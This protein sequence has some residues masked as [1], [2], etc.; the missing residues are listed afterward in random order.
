MA[1]RINPQ[2]KQIL[3]PKKQVEE[4]GT[5]KSLPGLVQSLKID[6]TMAATS[7]SLIGLKA[8]SLLGE[9][10]SRVQTFRTLT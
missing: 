9:K 4:I 7:S 8:S 1:K 10:S 2:E 3:I 6:S 5:K